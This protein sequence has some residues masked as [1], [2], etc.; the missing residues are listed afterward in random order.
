MSMCIVRVRVNGYKGRVC[1][2]YPSRYVLCI[3]MVVFDVMAATHSIVCFMV[4]RTLVSRLISFG[5]YVS[6]CLSDVRVMLY[7]HE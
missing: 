6:V 7:I 1:S 2:S 4:S 5:R 3:W